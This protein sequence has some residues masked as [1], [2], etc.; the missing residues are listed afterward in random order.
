MKDK[1]KLIKESDSGHCCFVASVI[2]MTKPHY[3][4][5]DINEELE[6]LSYDCVCECFS[7][8]NAQK[9]CDALNNQHTREGVFV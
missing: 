8:E 9:V 6:P 2:D 4:C 1:Y 7:V 5:D 3:H